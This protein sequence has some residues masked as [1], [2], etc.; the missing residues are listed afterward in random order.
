M[1]QA[2]SASPPQDRKVERSSLSAMTVLGAAGCHLAGCTE[3]DHIW[4]EARQTHTQSP[5]M[6][7]EKESP[8]DV[9]NLLDLTM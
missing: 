9:R 3:R 4:D 2:G 6:V 5:G 7:Q 8:G 1:R